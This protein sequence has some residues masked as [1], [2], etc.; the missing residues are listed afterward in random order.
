MISTT[1]LGFSYNNKVCAV[2]NDRRSYTISTIDAEEE[3]QAVLEPR[4]A[5]L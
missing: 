5:V 2:L 4:S 3:T 1:D